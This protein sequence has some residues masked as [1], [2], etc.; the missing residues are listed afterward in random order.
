MCRDDSIAAQYTQDSQSNTCTWWNVHSFIAAIMCA[1]LLQ[2]WPSVGICSQ[3]GE[4]IP[5]ALFPLQQASRNSVPVL[6]CSLF[7]GAEVPLITV[8]LFPASL[9]PN[10]RRYVFNRH[11][12]E[13]PHSQRQVWK[14]TV[15]FALKTQIWLYYTRCLSM[16]CS[17][18]IDVTMTS[19]PLFL[20]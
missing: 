18:T 3:M 10:E 19:D 17:F 14:G 11:A 6:F 9:S 5:R 20:Y 13:E 7:Q 4:K 1:S 12:I 2:F 8:S 15:L 16:Y